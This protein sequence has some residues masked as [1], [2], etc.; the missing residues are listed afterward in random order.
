[1]QRSRVNNNGKGKLWVDKGSGEIWEFSF[2]FSWGG[3][4]EHCKLQSE[5]AAQNNIHSV[6]KSN[7]NPTEISVEIQWW[8]DFCFEKVPNTRANFHCL[9]FSDRT[10]FLVWHNEYGCLWINLNCLSSIMTV[11]K[12]TMFSLPSF[13][14]WLEH[15]WHTPGLIKRFICCG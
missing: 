6:I 14:S 2:F 1:M 9:C 13:F 7:S 3:G 10:V 15:I 8:E 5:A 4:A 11:K 12:I